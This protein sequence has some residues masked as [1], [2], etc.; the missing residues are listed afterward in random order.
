ML[1]FPAKRPELAKDARGRESISR[2]LHSNFTD[3]I[4]FPRIAYA[5]LAGDDNERYA[6]HGFCGGNDVA[7]NAIAV[8]AFTLR[9]P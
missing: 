6:G 9:A 5:M 4:P 1:S 8:I 2:R 3:W 7:V